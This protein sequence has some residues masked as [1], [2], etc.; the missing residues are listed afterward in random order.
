MIDVSVIIVNYNSFHLLNECL[1]S[2]F[3]FNKEIQLDV[4]V[5]D[6]N[7]TEGNVELITS[8]YSTVKLIKN[9]KNIGFAAANNLALMMVKSKYTLFLNNDTVFKDNVIEK[10]FAFAEAIKQ[11]V[12]VGCQ[13]L[14]VD[15]TKQESVVEF[16][17]LWNTI[18]ENIF[19]YKIFKR[20]SFFNKYYQNFYN[21]DNP[22]EVDVIKGAFMFCTTKVILELNGFDDRFFFYSEE[23][24]LCYR[25]KKSGGKVFFLPD[26]KLIHY[27][28]ESTDKNLWFKYR[29]QTTGK[30]Q[31]YQKHFY[32]IKFTAVIF[33]HFTGLFLRGILFS[34]SGLFLLQKN[35]MKKGYY[36][37]KQMFVYPK[38]KFVT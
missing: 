13:L 28:G 24:D 32:G 15:K 37:F 22:V 8:K 23:T 31:F 27:G 33:I 14:N 38:N 19:L 5:V 2:L 20:Y 16:P 11:P 26:V 4:I 9:D 18:T 34:V 6:N 30:I 17:N 3:L 29:N 36:F 21:Y 35:I 12:F 1:D 7:S 25:F 10:A